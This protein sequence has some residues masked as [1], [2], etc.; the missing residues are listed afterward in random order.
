M[1]YNRCSDYKTQIITEAMETA[2]CLRSET[3]RRKPAVETGC[4][5]PEEKSN[6]QMKL[7]GSGPGHYSLITPRAHLLHLAGREAAVLSPRYAR[8]PGRLAGLHQPPHF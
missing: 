5:E 3:E 6:E 4:L 1:F 8:V 7:I 2:K